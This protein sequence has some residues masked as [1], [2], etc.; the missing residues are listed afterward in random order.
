MI[1]IA[2]QQWNDRFKKLPLP[3]RAVLMDPDNQ[4]ADRVNTLC[5]RHE[6]D[7]TQIATITRLTAHLLMGFILPTE[8]VRK[9]V[10]DIGVPRDKAILITQDLNRDVFNELKDFLKD[11]HSENTEREPT[12]AKPEKP[13]SIPSAALPAVGPTLPPS[14]TGPIRSDWGW[15][16]AINK[17]TGQIEYKRETGVP[18]TLV[19]KPSQTSTEGPTHVGSIFEQKLGG[20][21]RM[22]G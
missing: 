1:T 8:F 15:H 7:D 18:E 2:K 14:P 10:E 3:I 21:F 20:A 9:I 19:K 16:G 12:V 17:T 6:L 11:V 13:A 4:L 5:Q 22:K